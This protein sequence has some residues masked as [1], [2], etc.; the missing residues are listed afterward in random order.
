MP[1]AAIEITSLVKTYGPLRAVD[2]LSLRIEAGE[3][4][5]L[6]GPN[7]AGKTTTINTIVGL[8]TIQ[9]GQVTVF[10]HDVVTDYREARR[11]IGVSPQEFNFDRY[12][13]IEEI[14]LYTAG[15]FGIPGKVAKPR[16]T[17]LL[18]QFDLYQKKD[19]DYLKLSGGMKRR[20]SL[21]RALVYDPRILILDEPTAGVDVELRLELWQL[22]RDLN[23][24]GMTIVLTTHYLEEAQDLCE[25]IGI[26]DHGRLVALD[27]TDDLLARHGEGKHL[28]DVFLEL[29]A[30]VKA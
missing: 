28:Q 22:L 10:G 29:T 12:L 21:A 24:S 25:R 5:G 20:L 11:Q 23:K 1:D 9:Q 7:G 14:L 13:T 2:G 30:R 18:K 27:R 3:F 4:F 16:A 8:S 6:L 17:A 26:I 15:Y 19:Q